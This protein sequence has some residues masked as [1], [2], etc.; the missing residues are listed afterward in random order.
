M[1]LC[2]APLLLCVLMTFLT[3]ARAGQAVMDF[4]HLPAPSANNN[5]ASPQTEDGLRLT[6]S[7]GFYIFGPGS[8]RNTGHKALA[9]QFTSTTTTLNTV[10]G[11]KFTL[12]SMRLSPYAA[13]SDSTVTFT[14]NKAGG[15]TVTVSLTTG[16]ALAGAVRT[17]P[18]SFNDLVSVTWNM[19]AGNT[20][21][22]FDDITVILPPE[23][24]VHPPQTVTES[25]GGVTVGV[26][27]S[28]P[29]ATPL[30]MQW[31]ASS[32]TATATVDYALS[33]VVGS[34][35]TI[36]AGQRS[37]STVLDLVN[38][39]AVEPLEDFTVAFSTA[40]T[41]VIFAGAVTSTT[42]FIASED[43][44]TGFPGWMSAHGL[45]GNAALPNADPNGDGVSNIESW[46]YKINPA[47]PSPQAWL[48]RRAVFLF[49]AAARPAL[50]FTVPTPLPNDVRIIFEETAALSTWSEQARRTG[51]ALGSLWTGTGSSRVSEV[52][53]PAHRILTCAGSQTT[54][55]RS[56]AWLRMKFEYVAGGGGT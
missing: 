9:N 3:A 46:L 27:L 56:K 1:K 36:P 10:S 48:D 12:L 49:D 25:S 51:F 40:S 32:G 37:W 16:A 17:F 34:T 13:G 6:N 14:G 33:G 21:H 19:S 53:N 50:R 24:K 28:E 5:I 2:F 30:A 22:Q 39:T 47:G 55:Q 4:D 23:I 29:L 11:A 18:A 42:V 38:D 43:G 41:A 44:V 20:Y 26:T 52:N 31:N 45:N 35:F 15:G 54:R 8:T 7:N